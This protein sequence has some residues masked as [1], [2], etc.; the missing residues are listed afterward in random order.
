MK[1]DAKVK[2]WMILVTEVTQ[3]HRQSHHSTERLRFPIHLSY[4]LAY[5]SILCRLQ[6]IVSYLAKLT[7]F[8]THV[9]LM[10]PLE[11]TPMEFYEDVLA[12]RN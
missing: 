4:K 3:G 11:M 7:N 2:I 8:F 6:D 10:Y 9:Y 5:A 12:L 1:K